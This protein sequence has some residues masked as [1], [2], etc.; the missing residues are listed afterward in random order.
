MQ[1]KRPPGLRWHYLVLKARAVLLLAAGKRTAALTIFERLLRLVPGDGCALASQAHVQMQ[2]S[3]VDA[4]IASLQ[5]LTR[6]AGLAADEAVPWFNL[7]Y[8]LQQARRADDVR[9]A[10]ARNPRLDRAWYGLALVLI[11]QRQFHGAVEALEKKHRAAAHE[12]PRL[13]PA[14]SGLAG[15]GRG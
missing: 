7:G 8:A 13:V 14:G 4:A 6:I 9:S 5:A 12:P 11:E 3:Q 15:A 1:V 10:L 2:L